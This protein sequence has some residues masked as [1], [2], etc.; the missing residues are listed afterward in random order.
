MPAQHHVRE[1]LPLHQVDY[2]GR[3]RADVDAR[4]HQMAALAKAGQRRSEHL[5]ALGFQEVR[6]PPPAPAAMPG[7]VNQDK[8]V[9]CARHRG[10]PYVISTLWISGK[11]LSFQVNLFESLTAVGLR[12]I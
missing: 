12:S 5:V 7:A 3:V 4:A 6:D 1:A 10:S 9:A 8:R 2:V 11:A